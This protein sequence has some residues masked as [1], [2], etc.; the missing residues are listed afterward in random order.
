MIELSK[1]E[2]EEQ[3]SLWISS[4]ARD[5]AFSLNR[6][7]PSCIKKIITRNEEYLESP[8]SVFGVIRS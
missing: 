3:Y 7:K 1:K 4:A 2:F 5:I 8:E 6:L